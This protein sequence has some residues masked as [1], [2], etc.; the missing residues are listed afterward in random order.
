MMTMPP[1]L[2]RGGSCDYARKGRGVLSSPRRW[3]AAAKSRGAAKRKARRPMTPTRV[4]RTSGGYRI[5]VEHRRGV[6]LETLAAALKEA[7]G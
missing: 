2:R 1:R 4:L 5:K 7:R 3:P 6:I